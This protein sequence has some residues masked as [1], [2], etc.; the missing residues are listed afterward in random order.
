MRKIKIAFLCLTYVSTV[1]KLIKLNHYR[2]NSLSIVKTMDRHK[3]N[4]NSLNHKE[5]N[6]Y[7]A[8]KSVMSKKEKIN[9]QVWLNKYWD[10][11]NQYYFKRTIDGLPVEC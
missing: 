4:R 5:L 8:L 7:L 1:F 10:L 6:I 9:Y 2:T 11:R 3:W